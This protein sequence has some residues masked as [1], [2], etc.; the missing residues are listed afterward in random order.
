[1]T[2][3]PQLLAKRV[4]YVK[5]IRGLYRNERIAG[6]VGSLV[7]ALLLIWGRMGQGAPTWAVPVAF[8]VIGAAWS[9]FAYVIIRRTRYVRAHPFD[10][11]S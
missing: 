5:A 1:M 10:P 2:D 6:L 8:L 9:L 11:Q 7:G 3:D 4:A